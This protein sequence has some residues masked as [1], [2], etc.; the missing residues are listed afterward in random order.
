MEN[1]SFQIGDPD[2]YVEFLVALFHQALE[3]GAWETVEY[4]A[5]ALTEL[6]VDP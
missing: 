1:R 3:V 5:N 2:D 6:G 4:C